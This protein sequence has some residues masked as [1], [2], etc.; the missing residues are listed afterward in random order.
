LEESKKK[1]NSVLSD[2]DSKVA[3]LKETKEEM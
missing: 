2:L 3:K 1:F